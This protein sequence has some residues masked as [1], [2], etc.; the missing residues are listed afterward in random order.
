M[1]IEFTPFNAVIKR[2]QDA[3]VVNFIEYFSDVG[4]WYFNGEHNPEN[5]KPKEEPKESNA[6]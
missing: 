2:T 1:K 4:R 5:I 3:V 6:Q